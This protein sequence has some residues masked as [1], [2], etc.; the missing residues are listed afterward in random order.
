M[1]SYLRLPLLS[2]FDRVAMACNTKLQTHYLIRYG[3]VL[4]HRGSVSNTVE[5]E[6]ATVIG[7]F[8]FHSKIGDTVCSITDAVSFKILKMTP[9]IT[10]NSKTL[11]IHKSVGGAMFIKRF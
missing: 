6:A 7:P 3:A 8:Y 1:K 2:Q 10:R 9:S 11:I 5:V 4:H